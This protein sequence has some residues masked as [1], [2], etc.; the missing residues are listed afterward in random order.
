MT[1]GYKPKIMSDAEFAK[2]LSTPVDFSSVE[3]NKDKMEYNFRGQDNRRN[4]DLATFLA[5]TG[6]TGGLRDNVI[7]FPVLMSEQRL[8]LPLMDGYI[9][10]RAYSGVPVSYASSGNDSGSYGLGS[11]A[12]PEQATDYAAA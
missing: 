11:G 12:Y 9:K 1:E 3:A 10:D 4:Y 5:Q 8:Q 6:Q 7:P 2:T